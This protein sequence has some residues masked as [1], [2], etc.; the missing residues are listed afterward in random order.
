[1]GHGEVHMRIRSRIR[2]QDGHLEPGPSTDLDTTLWTKDATDAA[3]QVV[4]RLLA[5]INR[6]PLG[7]QLWSA[8]KE[9]LV[10]VDPERSARIK[11]DITYTLSWWGTLYYDDGTSK[12]VSGE[13][14]V[15]RP[16]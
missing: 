7:N 5:V 3:A 16:V 8:L 9:V 6:N 12:H 1:V 14:T 10:P 4:R 13:E 11:I 2:F 15:V